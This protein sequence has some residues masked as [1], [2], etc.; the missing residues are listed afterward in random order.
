MQG[1]YRKTGLDTARLA[2]LYRDNHEIY[3]WFKQKILVG[4]ISEKAL[5][6]LIRSSK[7]TVK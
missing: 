5:E 1:P 4:K 2:E 6:I 7:E 3:L